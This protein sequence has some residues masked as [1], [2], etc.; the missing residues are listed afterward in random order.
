MA[1]RVEVKTT[2]E[3]RAPR[4]RNLR[5]KPLFHGQAGL[6][7]AGSKPCRQDFSKAKPPALDAN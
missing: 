5:Q 6:T 2:R 3:I 1:G 7:E 4:F